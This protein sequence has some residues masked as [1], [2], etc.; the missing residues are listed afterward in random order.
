ML[1]KRQNLV[2]TMQGGHPDRFVKQFEAFGMVRGTPI[3]G[4]KVKKGETC[5]NNWGI[6]Y[7]WPENAP[8]GMPVNTTDTV[9]IK[10]IEHWKDYV[11]GPDLSKYTAA[12][13]E[14]AIA[15][16]EQFDRDDV[17]V[18]PFVA[19]GIFEQCHYLTEI[20][21]CLMYYITNPDEM[22]ELV[23]YITDWEL[24]LAEQWCTYVKPDGLFH[25]DDWGTQASTFLSPDMFADFFLDAY[26]EVYGY[27]KD[28]G[29]KLV[30]HHADCYAATLVP[31]MIEMGIDIWQGPQS[32]NNIPELIEK[33]GEKITF[34]GGMDS[35]ILDKP[36][37]NEAQIKEVTDDVCREC[38]S[39][40]DKHFFIPCLSQGLGMS[41]F[42]E[43]YPLA[44]KAI[45]EMSKEMF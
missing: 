15:E 26:K 35:G 24:Q 4:P 40:A 22:H 6:T 34:M 23:K 8:G 5:V 11:H 7:T 19:P 41:T 37:W 3:D 9:V 17:F 29:V 20:K 14:P 30:V 28:H 33:Y 27:Y 38:G 44:S 2:E 31:D 43:V 12:D 42:P 45:H 16:A 1:T 39:V 13:W 32:T 36:D 21:R 10:D 25:H 18:M